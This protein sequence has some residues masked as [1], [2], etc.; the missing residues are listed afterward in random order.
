MVA[1]ATPGPAVLYV[2]SAGISGGLRGYGP[3]ALGILCADLLYFALSMAGLGTFVLASYHLFLAIK[4]AGAV[5]LVW[6]GLRLWWVALARGGPSLQSSPAAS[7][8]RWL[9]GGFMV[10]AANPKAL[11]Y[12]GSIVPQFLRPE[13]PLL[14]QIATL[15]L[16]HLL[17]ALTV[18]LSYGLFAAQ[19]R[20]YARNPWFARSLYGVSGSMLIAAGAGLASLRKSAQ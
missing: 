14:P 12:F 17:T 3:G 6:L 13:K 18:L 20:A 19:V 2:L 1:T 9:S 11:L 10:H 4:W 7:R 5:Y 8:S 15:G 16:L